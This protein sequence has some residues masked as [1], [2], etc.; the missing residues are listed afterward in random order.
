MYLIFVRPRPFF[1]HG[2]D[3]PGW[4]CA[5]FSSFLDGGTVR[6]FFAKAGL[7]LPFVSFATVGPAGPYC[8]FHHG[9]VARPFCSFRLGGNARPFCFSCQRPG[10]CSSCHGGCSRFVSLAGKANTSARVSINRFFKL[11]LADVVN[12]GRCSG[13][14]VS[15][16]DV[17]MCCVGSSTFASRCTFSS[18]LFSHQIAFP[19]PPPSLPYVAACDEILYFSCVCVCVFV[20]T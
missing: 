1:V 17:G 11:D 5:H 4:C 12:V 16:A 9:G 15:N 3:W 6:P 20:C 18:R 7:C 19:D 13:R 14:P 8:L 10:F 2:S